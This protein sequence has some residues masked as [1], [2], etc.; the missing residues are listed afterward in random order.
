MAYT[1]RCLLL[2]NSRE[3]KIIDKGCVMTNTYRFA[4]KY[5]QVS[6]VYSKVHELCSDYRAEGPADFSVETGQSDIDFERMR[7]AR[8]DKA[9][10][11]PCR[12][13]SDAYLETLAV[14]RKIAERMPD[15]DTVLFHGSCVAVDGAGYL[16]I[17]KSGTGKSTHTRLWRELLGER[18]VM[19]NDDKPFIRLTDAGA[20]VYGTPWNGKHRLGS[21]ISVPLKAICILAR[22]AENNICPVTAREAYPMLL[23][24][25]YRPMDS[26]AMGKTIALIDQLASSVNLWRLG[27]NMSIE[28]AKLAYD[29]MKG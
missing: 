6:S 16:F 27:C 15:F 2:L 22:A 11:L 5:I 8:E 9:E 25:V 29:T 13:F 3:K 7:S 14:Y 21:N 18:A 10:G 12:S 4:D 19:V 23:Q 17:A 20:V 26:A 24:Q 28:A 1:L